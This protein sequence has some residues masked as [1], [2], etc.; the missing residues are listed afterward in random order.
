MPTESTLKTE[1]NMNFDK[2]GIVRVGDGRGFIV[3]KNGDRFILT[4][5]H[6]LPH[7]PPCIFAPYYTEEKTYGDLLGPL[8]GATTVWAE[9]LFADPVSDIAVLGTPDDQELTEQADLY[10]GLVQP[11]API[12][13][14]NT[15]TGE[16]IWALDLDGEFKSCDVA[17]KFDEQ[18]LRVNI[19]PDIIKPGMSGS[20]ILGD[21]GRAVSLVSTSSNLAVVNGFINLQGCLPRWFLSR[22]R[23]RS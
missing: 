23:H 11:A 18:I 5:A 7:L 10:Q 1:G 2:T 17:N 13:I 22:S 8:G 20:P 9:C 3:K 15:R 4:A 6:C 21:D 12:R 19:P 16:K 14:R